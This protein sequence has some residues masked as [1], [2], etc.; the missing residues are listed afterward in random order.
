MNKKSPPLTETAQ[1]IRTAANFALG[2]IVFSLVVYVLHTGAVILIPFFIAV[3]VWYLINAMARGIGSVS[4]GDIRLPRSFCFFLSMLILCG[5][6]WFGYK[7]I[8][9]NAA[10]ILRQA[11]Q[12]QAKL[13]E[14]A[15]GVLSGMPDSFRPSL[16]EVEDYL[17]IGGIMTAVLKTLSGV[18]GKT[19][20]VLFY[21]GFLLYEQQFFARKIKE[22]FDSAAAEKRM[23]G[24]LRSIDTNIQRYIWVKTLVSALTGLLT[25]LL[26]WMVGVN[27]A[28]FWGLLAFILNF[29]PYVGSLAAIILPS[30]I[31]LV[32]FGDFSV[33]AGVLVGLSVIQLSCGSILEPRLLG[34]RLNISP[35]FI[36]CNLAMW[37]LIW[38]VPGMFLSIPIL[39]MAI[40]TLAQFEKTRPLAVLLSKT[41]DINM[42]VDE[43][44]AQKK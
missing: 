11:P 7:L 27:Y 39:A 41:G 29:I 12:Y 20:I 5:G 4:F 3:F 22:M 36:I 24:I 15:Q 31:A 9:L 44:G 28:E 40:I 38:G 14:L 16:K 18:A 30:V 17:N 13:T 35:I 33:L 32:Q 34:D 25:W 19:L 6:L 21:T 23:H 8:S 37:G 43:K 1:P 10:T 26:L 42:H 2:F